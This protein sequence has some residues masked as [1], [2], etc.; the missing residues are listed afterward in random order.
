MLKWRNNK[1]A[2]SQS[3][4]ICRRAQNNNEHRALVLGKVLSIAAPLRTV[5]EVDE[6]RLDHVDYICS[7]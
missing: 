6:E 1:D 5:L 7:E 2:F 4:F 3:T